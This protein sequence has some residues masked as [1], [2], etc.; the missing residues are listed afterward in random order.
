MMLCNP[1]FHWNYTTTADIV[2]NQ[3]GT[4]SSK[5]Y[6]IMQVLFKIA[7]ETPGTVITVC[8]QDVPNLKRGVI[9]DAVS[10]I[11][12]FPL[13]ASLIKSYNHSEKTYTFQN[14]SIIE[15]VSYNNSQDAKSGKRDYLFVNEA[16]GI[17]Y[18]I[19]YELQ[20]RTRKKVYLDYNPNAAFWVH[21]KLLPLIGDPESEIKVVR[22]ISNYTHNKYLDAG[23]IK[24]IEAMK[25]DP[26][27]WR[28]YG[29]GYTGKVKGLIFPRW[30]QAFTFPEDCNKIAYGLDFGFSQS[31][32]ALVKVGIYD[33]Q[34]FAKQLVY[35][36]ELSNQDLIEKIKSFG[37]TKE[38]IY[39]D[40]A[41][42]KSIA[43]MRKAGLNVIAV[44]KAGDS[45]KFSI[46]KLNEYSAINV[47]GLDFVKEI[48]IYAYKND[49]PTKEHDHLLDSLRYYILGNEGRVSNNFKLY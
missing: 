49:K 34:V 7:L 31:S 13:L 5:T 32:C 1:V 45:V 46:N 29:L 40:S 11:A 8:G 28:V 18:E 10:I 26:N 48:S 3:G 39:A 27:L 42:P 12:S 47:I 36:T 41:E 23:V 14:D 4:S 19:Y 22:F 37:I 21:E 6:S 9:R 35:E 25:S 20:I 2:I 17:S 44:N 24:K 38:P 43:E 33:R 15:F 16:N 30:E